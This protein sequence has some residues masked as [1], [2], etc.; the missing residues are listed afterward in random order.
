ML[1]RFI[2][3]VLVVGVTANAQQPAPPGMTLAEASA[4]RFPQ[5]VQVRDLLNREVLRP[6]ESQPVV[7]RVREI[8][9]RADGKIEVVVNFGGLFG[10][11]TRPVAVPVDA[12]VLVGQYLE[13][14]DFTPDQLQQFKTFDGSDTMPLAL[15]S[16]LRVGL[17]RPSH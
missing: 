15:D 7:G 17:A 1:L 10:F 4:R 13:I 12:M 11:F 14:V 6:V 3:V 2:T 9:K 16:V 5:P 8:V